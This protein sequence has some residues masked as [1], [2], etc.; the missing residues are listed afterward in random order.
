[1]VRFFFHSVS[2]SF[3]LPHVQRNRVREAMKRVNPGG[4]ALRSVTSRPARRSYF[5]PG[6]NSL[7]H[8]DG[9]LKLVR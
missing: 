3:S 1:M 8:I 2:L 7:L 5:V 9:N 4:L 6:P